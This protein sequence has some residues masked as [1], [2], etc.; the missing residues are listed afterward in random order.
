MK[1]D[2]HDARVPLDFAAHLRRY[3]PERYVGQL[4]P[5]SDSELVQASLSAARQIVLDTN[6][7]INN[8][9]GRLPSDAAALLD[10]ALRY[11]CSVCFG[12]LA[13]GLAKRAQ[14]SAETAKGRAHYTRVLAGIPKGRVLTPTP[15]M[16]TAAGLI[17]GTLA[18]TQGLQPYQH[19]E[20]LNDA[21]LYL[22]AAHQ[23][24]PV[25]TSNKGDFDLIQQVSGWGQ[26][27]YYDPI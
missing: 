11:H 16:W 12:E 3:A 14:G 2:T 8:Y 10:G 6:V 25:L 9:A 17:A 19:R 20:M 18:R 5:R 4:H 26:F 1:Q 21:L 22:S 24:L 7:Y 27:I 13:V 23:G 15:D